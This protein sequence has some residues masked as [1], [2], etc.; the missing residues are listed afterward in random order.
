MFLAPAFIR[1]T[2]EP[3]FLDQIQPFFIC[4]SWI[5]FKHKNS[6]LVFYL[7]RDQ[8]RYQKNWSEMVLYAKTRKVIEIPLLLINF[9]Y[10]E[11]GGLFSTYEAMLT[12]LHSRWFIFFQNSVFR[13]S[14]KL[15]NGKQGFALTNR[16]K[17]T[18]TQWWKQ[19]FSRII[20]TNLRACSV[21]ITCCRSIRAMIPRQAVATAVAAVITV[22]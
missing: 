17:A 21:C 8:H 2:T 11:T 10:W 13:N 5:S 14:E 15:H 16:R 18:F 20:H 19:P 3:A 22:A 9:E 12:H 1:K 6:T 4:T 7:E